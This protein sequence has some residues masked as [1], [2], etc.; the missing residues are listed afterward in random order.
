CLP[1]PRW[2]RARIVRRDQRWRAGRAS[3]ALTGI[4]QCSVK[5]RLHRA[6]WK[7]THSDPKKTFEQ[8]EADDVHAI[9]DCDRE[10]TRSTG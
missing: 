3:F 6:P 2:S 7:S 1:E 5:A 8:I 9:F 10:R 4:R